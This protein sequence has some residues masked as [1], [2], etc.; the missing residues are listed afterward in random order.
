[1]SSL[2]ANILGIGIII[3]GWDSLPPVIVIAP[4]TKK[5]ESLKI[6]TNMNKNLLTKS[7]KNDKIYV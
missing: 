2:S 1:M 5:A 3:G 4:P 7:T 6:P